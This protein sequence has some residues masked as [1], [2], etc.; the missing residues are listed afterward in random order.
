MARVQKRSSTSSDHNKAHPF[1][2]SSP[3][4]YRVGARS[5]LGC[6][7]RKVRCDRGVPC[8]NCSSCGFSCVYP[9]KDSDVARKGPTLQDISNRLERLES[10]LS[11][12]A[13]GIRVTA[14]STADG[15]SG[16]GSE[17]QTQVQLQS[18]AN[19]NP[20][21]NQY[22][23]DQRPCKSTWELLLNDGQVVR[24]VN[25]LNIE[26]LLQDVGLDFFVEFTPALLP[27]MKVS[28]IPRPC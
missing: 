1:R 16:S 8:A 17:S 7:R 9:R 3:Q 5:C 23:S 11:R 22:P 18:D 28:Y 25:N 15:G 20:T 10:L 24:Y 26:V 12:L 19:V 27:T 6:H 2:A 4:S 21:A 14:E 13:E